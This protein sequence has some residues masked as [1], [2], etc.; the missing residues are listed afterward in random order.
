L[1]VWKVLRFRDCVEN[2][3]FIVLDLLYAISCPQSI[4]RPIKGVSYPVCGDEG[5]NAWCRVMKVCR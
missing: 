1:V 3:E 5:P 4:R 2:V